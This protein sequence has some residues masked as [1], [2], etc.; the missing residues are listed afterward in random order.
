[1]G[2]LTQALAGAIGGGA[3]SISNSMKQADAFDAQMLLENRRQQHAEYL[4]RLQSELSH[5]NQDSGMVGENGESLSNK[6]WSGLSEDARS[7]AQSKADYAQGLKD[8]NEVVARDNKTSEPLKRGDLD[9]R[10][11]STY[12]FI[13][14]DELRKLNADL[15]V[16]E[17][18][19]EWYGRKSEVGTGLEAKYNAQVEYIKSL[20]L[21]PEQEAAEILKLNQA[22]R[23]SSG[24]GRRDIPGHT[25]TILEGLKQEASSAYELASKE[26]DTETR[27]KLIQKGDALRKQ[28]NSTLKEFGKPVLQYVPST[29]KDV[30]GGFIG[31]EKKTVPGYWKFEGDESSIPADAQSY[32]E[33]VE[34]KN[35]LPRGTL[36]SVLFKESSRGK[37]MK[38]GA[39]AEGY[40]GFM[41]DTAKQYNVNPYDFYSSA[42]GAGKMLGELNKKYDGNIKLALGGYNWGQGKVD[43]A[44]ANGSG[45]L[46]FPKETRN[47]S[48]DIASNVGNS[49]KIDAAGIAKRAAANRARDAEAAKKNAPMEATAPPQSLPIGGD[50]IVGQQIKPN[51][52]RSW[53]EAFGSAIGNTTSF[54]QGDSGPNWDDVL[55]K[56]NRNNAIFN[57]DWWKRNLQEL[58]DN[59]KAYLANIMS[60]RSLTEEELEKVLSEKG[61]SLKDFIAEFKKGYKSSKRS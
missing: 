34:E 32:M 24:G 16:K 47:Y 30:K 57:K 18:Q 13:A 48:N 54:M 19:A 36:D 46:S 27:D 43:N 52:D 9:E 31:T 20:N 22:S 11:P 17:K 23:G 39:G 33:K 42:D 41:P 51:N 28:V 6:D 21:P 1:M 44:V 58:T 15:G 5:G 40:F 12:T 50:G 38:S 61:D 25:D 7:K 60:Q 14:S 4:T 35:G 56:E 49:G 45:M 8:D 59:E 29:T 55:G 53:G 2:M 3:E 37:N 26:K 10:D